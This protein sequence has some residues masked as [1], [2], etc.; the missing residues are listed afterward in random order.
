MSRYSQDKFVS[1]DFYPSKLF[2]FP[3]VTYLLT[4]K[5]KSVITK[6]LREYD[7]KRDV[8][9]LYASVSAILD[10]PS[11]QTIW[12]FIFIVLSSPH[13]EYVSHRVPLAD[14]KLMEIVNATGGRNAHDIDGREQEADGSEF[15]DFPPSFQ[16]QID[17]LLTSTE[18]LQFK[19][20][21]KQYGRAQ[22]LG[23]LVNTLESIL[24][25]PSKRILWRLVL[26]RMT[27]GHREVMR[28]RLDL[29]GRQTASAP[30]NLT[31]MDSYIGLSDGG[32]D[33]E[34]VEGEEGEQQTSA[35]RKAESRDMQTDQQVLFES[36]DEES[37]DDSSVKSEN[38]NRLA[39]KQ[40]TADESNTKLMQELEQTRKAVLEMRDAIMAQNRNSEP[41]F[42]FGT[43][44]V[45]DEDL[46]KDLEYLEARNF[47]TVIPVGQGR[48]GHVADL[49]RRSLYHRLAGSARI[50]A[51]TLERREVTID[52]SCL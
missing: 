11:K 2:T 26:P 6:S 38:K 36:E 42:L 44:D 17:F 7:I 46:R 39:S 29:H 51:T 28:G 35:E 49:R 12:A 20:C 4:P 45:T 30:L 52:V 18:R 24:D 43:D 37:S 40:P 1:W 21:L 13:R 8:V 48:P 27:S 23:Q 10:T 31:A 47:V 41:Q 50:K 16:Q 5:E 9:S 33:K 14:V 15:E 34:E 32:E 3:Q 22:D 19:Q 25:S